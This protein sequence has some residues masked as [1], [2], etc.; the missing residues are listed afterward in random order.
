MHFINE[1][2][3]KCKE[4]SSFQNTSTHPFTY[5]CLQKNTEIID[6]MH[7][8]YEIDINQKNNKNETIMDTLCKVYNKYHNDLE[9]ITYLFSKFD[10]III[11][12]GTFSEEI[13]KILNKYRT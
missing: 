11:P 10:D 8:R 4:M 9:M 2:L 1:L 3:I 5:A 12:D 6:L 13:E 7:Q